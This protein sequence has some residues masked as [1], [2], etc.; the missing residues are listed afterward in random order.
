[1]KKI[2]LGLS[3]L[4]ALS[5]GA[6]T[7]DF[8][9]GWDKIPAYSDSIGYGYDLRPTVK[10]G[11]FSPFMFSVKVPDGNYTV[12]VRFGSK[13]SAANTTLRAEH[14]RLLAENIRTAKGEIKEMKFTV[15]KRSPRID[16]KNV[17]L[18]KPRE[19]EYRTWDDRLNL[20][21]TGAAPAVESITVTP[22]D[23]S[24]T[25]I[26]LC[27]NS[28]VVDQAG[29]PYASWGQMIP[30]WFD[31][32]VCIANH[33]ESGLATS[34]FIAQ[35]RLDKIM[36]TLRPGDW[37]LVEFGHNDQKESRPGSGAYYNFAHNLKIFID[38]V[39]KAGG[40]IAFVTPTQRRAF[41]STRKH[42]IETH[43]D[44]PA[45]MEE[46]AARE[47]VPVLD[48]HGL[49]R[50]FFETLGYEGSKTALV[51][52]PANTFPNQPQALEDNTHFNPY[53]AAQIAKMV[54]MEL[55]R[56]NHP[57]IAHLRPDFIDYTPAS[58]DPAAE[59][60]WY[61]SVNVDVTKP[62]GN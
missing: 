33:A 43:R 29:D 46:V 61:P 42:I 44:Y 25:T 28:T 23:S 60:I 38:M 31:E 30:R 21:I 8:S 11:V 48:I 22:A 54:V 40:N 10:K 45:A 27:G 51:H 12:T 62:D 1:M 47:N 34:S 50:T 36:T 56:L 2:L 32:N 57:A 39:R 55:K 37:V 14:R 35:K 17:V 24:V 26:Y 20:E 49:T 9:K 18:I 4:A 6:E 16:D 3:M 13:K 52:Y 59:Y 5:A 15:N 58:P 53:G 41:D 7:Y 19:K